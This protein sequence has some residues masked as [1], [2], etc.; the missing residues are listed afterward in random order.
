MVTDAEAV[1]LAVVTALALRQAHVSQSS[2]VLVAPGEAP[3]TF[4]H[5]LLAES[6]TDETVGDP[7][8]ALS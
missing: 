3:A 5:E 8:A 2:V 4:D 7:L 6:L 1:T